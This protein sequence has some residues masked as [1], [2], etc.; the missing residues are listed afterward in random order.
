MTWK[1]LLSLLKFVKEIYFLESHQE[2]ISRCD[3]AYAPYDHMLYTA[4]IN[5]YINN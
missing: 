5:I 3:W 1:G 2:H 4:L